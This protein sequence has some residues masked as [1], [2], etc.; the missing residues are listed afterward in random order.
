MLILNGMYGLSMVV[1]HSLLLGDV[2]KEITTTTVDPTQAAGM[3]GDLEDLTGDKVSGTDHHWFLELLDL[4]I[5]FSHNLLGFDD[6]SCLLCGLLYGILIVALC[7]LMLNMMYMK[8]PQLPNACRMFMAFINLEIVIYVA[9][10]ICKL[11]KLC[12]MQDEFLPRLGMDCPVLRFL[13]LQRVVVFLTV[14]GLSCWTFSSLAYVLTF[15]NQVIDHPNFAHAVEM[16]HDAYSTGGPPGQTPGPGFPGSGYAGGARSYAQ[17]PARSYANYSQ[18]PPVGSAVS[19][20]GRYPPASRLANAAQTSYSIPNHMPRS[21]SSM[22]S[23][24]TSHSQ[25]RQGLLHP[26]YAVKGPLT[27]GP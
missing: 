16:Q 4:D 15:G 19:A 26:S 21:G 5:G 8:G 9:I 2:D 6:F 25:E 18:R 24:T 17:S 12:K 20:A 10:V 27:V 23:T 22:V 1:T 14:A 7:G 13:Y 3:G 11:P